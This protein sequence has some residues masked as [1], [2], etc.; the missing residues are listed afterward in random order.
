MDRVQWNER[1]AGEEPLFKADPAR[2]L[3]AEVEGTL[4]G[5]A[6]DLGCGDGRNALWLA[7]R[8]WHVTGVDFSDVALAKAARFAV[9]RG[10]P[11]ERLDLVLADLADYQPAPDAFELVLLLF[12]HPPAPRRRRM[13]DSAARA[14]RPGGVLLV[15]GY[16]VAN[17]TEGTAG[18]PRDPAVLFTAD[19]IVAELPPPLVV[20]RAERLRVP[21][22]SEDGERMAVDAVVRARRPG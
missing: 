15:V 8:G 14:L 3:A 2:F 9:A 16:D 1:Y 6:L 22:P 20:E 18:G 11:A 13:L 21:V 4:P 19:D 7:Q 10:V 5:R 17:A 12:V